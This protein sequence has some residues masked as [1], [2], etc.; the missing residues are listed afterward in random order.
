MT[1][2]P[3]FE[4]ATGAYASNGEYLR[5]EL[6]RVD[7]LVRAQVARW[8]VT[9]AASKPQSLWGMVHV[10]DAEID[11]YLGAE[12]ASPDSLPQG[13]YEVVKKFWD[14]EQSER[15]RIDRRVQATAAEVDLRIKRLR[16]QFALTPEE[17]DVLLL[18]LLA[19]VDF[20][21]GRVIGYLQD[22]ASRPCPLTVLLAQM[23]HPKAESLEEKQRLFDPAGALVA[24][25]LVHMADAD[26]GC[27]HTVSIDE[28]IAGFLLGQDQ[29]DIL[30]ASVLRLLPAGNSWDRIYAPD[31][32]VKALRDFA[33]YD[34]PTSV[35]VMHGPP[36]SG[37]KKAARAICS[38][39]GLALLE[40]N[41]E[42]ALHSR[43][44]WNFLL[45]LAY[46]EA[47]LNPAALYV[48]NLDRLPPEERPQMILEL[49][50]MAETMPT[51]TFVATEAAGESGH[52]QI[53]ARYIH[54]DFPVPHFDLRRRIWVAC[55]PE[56]EPSENR[57]AVAAKL[58]AA[59]QLNEGHITEA[60]AGA[61]TLALRRSFK[62]AN[63]SLHDL[64][65]ACRRQ[66]GSRLLGF[67][68]RIEPNPGLELHDVIL[69][70]ANKQ[71]LRELLDRIRLRAR[72]EQ[73]SMIG[74]AV[75]RSKG[76][77]ALFTGP[78]GT[79]KTLAAEV[80]AAQQGMDLYKIDI[81]MVVSK[82]LGETEK[83]LGSVFAEAEGSDALLFFDECDSLFGQRGEINEARDRWANLQTNYLLQRV[84]EYSGVVI[85]A[86]NL[87][88]N[89]DPAFLRR[90]QMIIEFPS[91]DAAMRL[92][93]WRRSISS[94]ASNLTEADLRQLAGR[95]SLSGGSIRNVAIDSAYRA[96]AGNRTKIELRDA[97][98]S[99]AR[100]YQKIGRPIT[101]GEF[102][103]QF[104]GWA[105][106]DVLT[107]QPA[108][109]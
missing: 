90:I 16:E 81:S 96:L 95:F 11:Q 50:R 12:I 79:G 35:V 59:F 72:E 1:E 30:A 102:G 25:R 22:D 104:Y 78:S 38:S 23:V 73:D 34:V 93:I 87:R 7:L 21:Y 36:G 19:E 83:N 74:A 77:V 37:R 57:E 32:T 56:I 33:A 105:L 46:R 43:T 51:L 70:S 8:R 99:I 5:E 20:R 3:K 47:R 39:R 18:C 40:L 76:L 48:T 6:A 64:Y 65:E 58:A 61:R 14:A 68:R 89:I 75:A 9:I 67:A 88:Q 27:R 66:A 80:I 84:E 92:A 13:L 100:E 54:F 10:S 24:W 4:L 52:S 26:G 71:Q 55:L 98:D 31:A 15:E 62:D 107:P 49:T 94:G 97:V 28:R 86:S 69:T 41:L 60:V 45:R 109:Q 53:L 82:W 29:P 101:Q 2:P 108:D 63:P 17:I 44:P 103:P 85:L 91:P 106:A 42:A